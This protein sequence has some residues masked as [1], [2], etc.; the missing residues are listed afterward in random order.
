MKK[1]LILFCLVFTFAG[2]AAGKE[3]IVL[4]FKTLSGHSGSVSSIAFSPDSGIL[5]AAGQR[6]TI[7]LWDMKDFHSMRTWKDHSDS[8]NSVFYSPGGKYLVSG[9]DDQTAILRS[10]TDY[11]P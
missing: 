3:K 11:A 10:A 9:S 7:N 2:V 5:V 6:G 4:P 8:V 1:S